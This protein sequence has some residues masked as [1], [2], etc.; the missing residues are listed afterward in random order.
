[1]Q[2][3]DV[4]PLLIISLKTYN[5]RMK[6]NPICALLAILCSTIFIFGASKSA[7]KSLTD[8]PS[9]ATIETDDEFYDNF[10]NALRLSPID[11]SD[12][13]SHSLLCSSPLIRCQSSTELILQ[14]LD[15]LSLSRSGQL[16]LN[17]LAFVDANRQHFS[18]VGEQL[19]LYVVEQQAEKNLNQAA[20]TNEIW[21]SLLKSELFYKSFLARLD[22]L[23]IQVLASYPE[24]FS[25]P[26]WHELIGLAAQVYP[27]EFQRAHTQAQ[28]TLTKTMVL[29]LATVEPDIAKYNHG[30]FASRP[31]VYMFCREDRSY[32][33]L[34]FIKNYQSHLQRNA[35]G[36]L[37]T[38]PSLGYSRHHKKYNQS[39]GNTPSG[40]FRIEGPMPQT[41]KPFAF[42][43]FRRLRLDFVA[44]SPNEID[45]QNLLPA[46]SHGESWWHEAI[47]ARD[48]G[49]GLFRIH[50][51]GVPS[52]PGTHFYPFVGTSG[53]VAK[54]ENHHDGIDYVDQHLFLQELMIATGLTPAP[55]NE[56][57]IKGLLYIVN[58]DNKR[59]AV[60]AQ[61]LADYGIK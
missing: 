22:P 25:G 1:L 28:T 47:V 58:I 9:D 4:G 24:Y 37:W 20:N 38:Q 23:A 19:A 55:D 43:K 39:N 5:H 11:A 44:T 61:D 46:S 7:A 45:Q 27:D 42:G 33:C 53:C 31:R 2:C 56:L 59:G 30:E 60:T 16:K 17:V 35:D 14:A 26:S 13:F 34:M 40:V 10:V 48:I 29:D 49:R 41:T 12:F 8:S 32:P 54:R 52:L 3:L 36:S 21:L 6:N 57:K 15:E 50:G 18:T 51:T